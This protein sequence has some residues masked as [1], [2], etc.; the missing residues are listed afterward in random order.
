M[1]KENIISVLNK[2][3]KNRCTPD[4]VGDEIKTRYEGGQK[5]A[6]YIRLKSLNNGQYEISDIRSDYHTNNR[7][8][9]KTNVFN[10]KGQI[11]EMEVCAE[12]NGCLWIRTESLNHIL[13]LPRYLGSEEIVGFTPFG[14]WADRCPIKGLVVPEGYKYIGNKAFMAYPTFSAPGI[15]A[16]TTPTTLPRLSNTGPPLLPG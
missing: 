16:F 4:Y 6:C 5:E 11:E 8:W 14:C 1:K 7:S 15:P 13:Y 9:Q 12:G 2:M 3:Q 10:Y